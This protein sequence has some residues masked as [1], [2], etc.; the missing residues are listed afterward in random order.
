M[1][2]WNH[3]WFV[4]YLWV[5]TLV[6]FIMVWLAP[7]FIPG[8]RHAAERGLAGLG[9]LF[10][11]IAWLAAARMGLAARFPQNHALV[12]DWYNHANYF[13]VF[14]LGF[15]LA[16]THAPWEALQRF[17]WHTLGAAI[18]GWSS[19]CAYFGLY[20]ADTAVPPEALRMFM[21]ALYGAQQWLAI[22]AVLGFAQRHLMRD[23]AARRYLTAAIFPV[24]ILHQTVIIVLAH[25]LQ[26][27]G[28]APPVEGLLLVATTGAA[29][30]LAYEVIRR[31]RLL[32]P[33]F[34][35]GREARVRDGAS[36]AQELRAPAGSF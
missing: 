30:F 25:A 4:A 17:R 23:N 32:Q 7:R 19:L 34:G 10:W 33:L 11:P 1:P 29:C 24:Y 35:V 14:L 36:A 6:L 2:T 21:R 3:L 27:A 12:G 18:L 20:S 8:L 5:Y 28:M 26:P 31:V 16:G 9:V 15:A 22:A 13:V